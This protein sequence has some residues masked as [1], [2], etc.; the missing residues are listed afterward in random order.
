MPC[1]ALVTTRRANSKDGW[2][3][4]ASLGRRTRHGGGCG[5]G[6][7]RRGGGAAA[8]QGGSSAGRWFCSDIKQP[9]GFP[10]R[11]NHPPPLY[12]WPPAVVSWR[13]RGGL[14]LPPPTPARDLVDLP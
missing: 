11:T 2:R 6:Y 8:Q 12:P 5:G 14:F 9:R 3:I 13:K 1:D 7:G 4:V 10:G